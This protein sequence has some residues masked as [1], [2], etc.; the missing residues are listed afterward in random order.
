M[1]S[2]DTHG[3]SSGGHRSVLSRVRPAWLG[4]AT[5]GLIALLFTTT[6]S[7][8][9]VF[10]FNSILLAAMG[11]I[12]LQVLQGTAGLVSVG[13]AAFLILGAYGSVFMLRLGVP[14]PL[15]IA[16][17][18]LI[19][20][21]GG[22]ITGLP[23]LRLR[24]LF[25][26]LATLSAHFIALFLATK[27]QSSVPEARITGFFVPIL[28]GSKGIEQSGKYWTW[29]LVGV[30]SLVILG[31]ARLM[32]ERSGRAMRM[33]RE[34]EFIAPTLGI[35]VPRYKLVVFTLSSMIVGCQGALLAHFNGSVTTTSFTLLLAFQYVAMVVIGG[36]DS[37]PG[38][39][40]G[41]AIVIALP[42]WVPDMV[43]PLLG[44]G[45]ALTDGANISLIIY[46]SLVILFVTASPQGVIGVL[47]NIGRKIRPRGADGASVERA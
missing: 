4:I 15:D 28:F 26:A 32:R 41:A 13:N 16:G 3:S 33:I 20:G 5:L 44:E 14:F 35:S 21:V 24:A 29:L 25:L 9:N 6:Q 47:R 8:Y 42:V 34:H 38:A 22:L 23:A 43:R 11:A 39:V 12:A 27:Y 40:I 1:T 36:L 10:V 31:A 46:G 37:L 19:A 45:R 30:L 7:S 17:A 18:T 2:A